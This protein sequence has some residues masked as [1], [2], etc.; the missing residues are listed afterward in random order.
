MPWT[1]FIVS[2][3]AGGTGTARKTPRRLFFSVSKTS[4]PFAR[5]ARSAVN[6]SASEIRHPAKARTPQNVRT[7]GS[8]LSAAARNRARSSAFTYF[9]LPFCTRSPD[10]RFI[11]GEK[12]AAAG[13][14]FR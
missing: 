10:N 4:M 8:W 14:A 12:N 5:S 2:R 1:R 7:S 11:L 6:S 9:R 3:S 13:A